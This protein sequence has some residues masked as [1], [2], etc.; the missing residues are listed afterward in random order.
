[1]WKNVARPNTVVS[2]RNPAYFGRTWDIVR[3]SSDCMSL[4]IS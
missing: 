4:E 2:S 3:W 1:M